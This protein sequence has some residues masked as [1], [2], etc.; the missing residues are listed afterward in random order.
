MGGGKR[1]PRGLGNEDE[2]GRPLAPEAQCVNTITRGAGFPTTFG[3]LLP[4]G[5]EIPFAMPP[6]HGNEVV[7]NISAS[8]GES[9]SGVKL[10]GEDYVRAK[11]EAPARAK[12]AKS[13]TLSAPLSAP[14]SDGR[15]RFLSTTAARWSTSM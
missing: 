15:R 8:E 12:G 3:P 2:K 4:G 13:S 10:E 14:L 5:R 7:S 9:M 11:I 6:L 1:F